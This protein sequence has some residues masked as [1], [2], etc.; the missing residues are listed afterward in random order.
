MLALGSKVK[1]VGSSSDCG[2]I[3]AVGS[4]Y[5]KVRLWPGRNGLANCLHNDV[6]QIFDTET[7]HNLFMDKVRDR[8]E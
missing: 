4:K 3:V 7:Q 1:Y 6:V 8:L 5:Y 2:T